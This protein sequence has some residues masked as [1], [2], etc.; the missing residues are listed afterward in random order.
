M[1]TQ[2]RTLVGR[3]LSLSA[4]TPRE[5]AVPL[6]T[7]I[8]FA[9]VIAPA[10]AKTVTATGRNAYMSFVAVG[11]VGLLVPIS[12]MFAG[13]GVLV[14]RQSGARR[15]LLAAP[16][17][18]PMIVL[19]NLVV[20]L[21]VSALQLVALIVAAVLRGATFHAAL[22]GAGWFVAASAGLAVA[23]YG[24]AEA[25]ANRIATQEEYVGAVPAIAIVPWFFAGSLFPI[26]ALPR[27]LAAWARVLPLTHALAVMRYGILDRTGAGLR[28]IWGMTSVPAMAVLSLAVVAAYAVALLAVSIRV[29]ARSAAG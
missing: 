22:T 10:L 9:V 2:F 23:M 6:L 7:P 19:A 8:L 29:F 15:D 11:T 21:A 13:I 26:H 12:C 4:R 14:D 3:R 18:R 28:D 27:A 16:V 20:A 5:V 25:L 1:M 24:G 17:P